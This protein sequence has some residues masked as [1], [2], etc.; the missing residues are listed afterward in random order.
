MRL[1]LAPMEGVVDHVM[2]DLLSTLGGLDRCVTEFVRVSDRRL[3]A[4]VFHRLCPELSRGGR[5][6]TGTPVYVQL[7]G[8]QPEVMALNAQRAAELGAPGIDLNFGCPAKTVNK[9]DG[10]AI[11]LRRPERVYDIVSAVRAAVPAHLPVTVKTRLGFDTADRFDD[12]LQAVAE[13]GPSELVIHARTKS[14]GYRPPA[15]WE[16]IARAR[17]MLTIPVVANGEI[18][19]AEDARQCRQISG[20]SDLMLGRGALCRP[21]LPRLIRAAEAG[22]VLTPLNWQRISELL[23]QF[24]EANLADY[25]AHYVGNPVKQWLVYLRSY[26]PQAGP[27]FE[28][29]KRLRE[30][31]ALRS[32][33]AAEIN[34]GANR[35]A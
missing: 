27:L 28:R 12:I 8:G 33:L 7:L 17:E 9:S 25:D 3:P 21:D 22:E 20:C 16:Y 10:G 31:R 26:Y 24:F 23:L 30:P 32:V 19:S 35:A 5:T 6:R 2:R 1:M 18:W 13:A 11:I 14:Q 34:G 29:L 4:R 15:H